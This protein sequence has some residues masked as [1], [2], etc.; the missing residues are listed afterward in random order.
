M[1]RM[2]S[3]ASARNGPKSSLTVSSLVATDSGRRLGCGAA[4]AARRTRRI[5]HT[6]GS[7]AMIAASGSPPTL[8]PAVPTNAPIGSPMTGIVASHTPR[9]PSSAAVRNGSPAAET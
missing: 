5:H 7:A 6:D 3:R 1:S 8:P 4:R 2:V 9:R